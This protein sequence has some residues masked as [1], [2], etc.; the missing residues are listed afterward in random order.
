MGPYTPEPFQYPFN[1]PTAN[2]DGTFTIDFLLQQPQRVT[3]A[4]AN[5]A[6]QRFYVDQIF[7]PS[8]PI[9]GGAVIYEQAN[10]RGRK[11]RSARTN[12]ATT[13]STGGNTWA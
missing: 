1:V 13:D 11:V 9:V 6:L 3:R 5:L 12:M 8:G 10:S 2:S 7:A 4:I